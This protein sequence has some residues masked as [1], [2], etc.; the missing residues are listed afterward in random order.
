MEMAKQNFD[1]GHIYLPK[2]R[3]CNNHPNSRSTAYKKIPTLANGGQHVRK[4]GYTAEWINYLHIWPY[5][6]IVKSD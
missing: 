5:T 3:G 2:T 6:E 1:F 4:A